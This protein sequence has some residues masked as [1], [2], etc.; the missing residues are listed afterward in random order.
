MKILN[1]VVFSFLML[2]LFS[3]ANAQI[4]VPNEPKTNCVSQAEM[5]EIAKHF[6]QFAPQANAEY[7][8]DG[9]TTAN[10]IS[11]L[12]FMRHTAFAPKMNPSKDDLFTGRFAKS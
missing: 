4:G 9:S 2:S 1:K 6:S 3:F 12:M 11:S 5:K 7:C 8:L 10:L